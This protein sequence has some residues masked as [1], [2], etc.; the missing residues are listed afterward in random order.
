MDT[1]K[2]FANSLTDLIGNTITGLLLALAVAVFFWSIIRFL[3]ARSSGGEAL[4]DAQNRLGWSVIGLFVMFSIWGIVTF[5][6]TGL[7]WTQTSITAPT[8][9]SSG[10]GSSSRGAAKTNTP[11]DK[12]PGT[13]NYAS[14]EAC[15]YYND[16]P[17]KCAPLPGATTYYCKN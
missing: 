12:K 2:D 3:I 17:G 15:N 16:C 14:L 7:G 11:A 1:F 9:N 8:I 5:L 10:G 13:S 6:Q 4:K